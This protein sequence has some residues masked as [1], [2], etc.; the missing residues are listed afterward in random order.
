MKFNLSIVLVSLDIEPSSDLHLISL[1]TCNDQIK[2]HLISR[3][4]HY[5]YYY[6]YYYYYGLSSQILIPCHSCKEL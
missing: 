1:S 2:V 3:A 5:Y 4:F 6:Y